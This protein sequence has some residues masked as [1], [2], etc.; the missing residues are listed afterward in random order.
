M[1]IRQPV[2]HC[3]TLSVLSNGP[4]AERRQSSIDPVIKVALHT[5]CLMDGVHKQMVSR[6]Q[7]PNWFKTH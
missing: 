2:R 4:A 7:S 5:R 6:I 3:S 1:C